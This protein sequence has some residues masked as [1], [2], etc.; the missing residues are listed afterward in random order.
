MT[1]EQQLRAFALAVQRARDLRL[2]P[3]YKH[4]PDWVQQMREVNAL[5]DEFIAKYANPNPVEQPAEVQPA[6]KQPAAKTNRRKK[7]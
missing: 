1:V 3:H 6:A 2:M 4:P 7:T 5:V